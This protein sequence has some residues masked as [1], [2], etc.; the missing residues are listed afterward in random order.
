MIN[1]KTGWPTSGVLAVTVS[2]PTALEADVWSTALFVAGPKEGERLLK[3]FPEIEAIWLTDPKTN[4]LSQQNVRI[5]PKHMKNV[6]W[7]LKPSV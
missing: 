6:V 5:V 2:A 1:P 4:A 7:L 3:K